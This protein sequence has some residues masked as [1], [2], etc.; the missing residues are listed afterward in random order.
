MALTLRVTAVLGSLWPSSSGNSHLPL[1][2]RGSGTSRTWF[3]H[4]HHPAGDAKGHLPTPPKRG[5]CDPNQTGALGTSSVEHRGWRRGQAVTRHPARQPA[6]LGE[7]RAT[8]NNPPVF[9]YLQN[10]DRSRGL[11]EETARPDLPTLR[12][13]RSHTP[14][15]RVPSP[16]LTWAIATSGDPQSRQPSPRSPAPHGPRW[17][18][19]P[20][21]SPLQRICSPL[22]RPPNKMDGRG[23]HP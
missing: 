22:W 19:S 12:G 4:W 8:K 9:K 13:P 17:L 2:Q 20:Q 5:C 14:F 7:R 23:L 1:P 6:S 3:S 16:S 10:R 18:Q 21:H 11:R 15:C